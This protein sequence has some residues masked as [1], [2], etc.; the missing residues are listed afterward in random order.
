MSSYPRYLFDFSGNCL[1][2]YIEF[3]L[4]DECFLIGSEPV[5]IEDFDLEFETT[6]GA[7]F[8][9]NGSPDGDLL[10]TQNLT[11]EERE[12]LLINASH[13]VSTFNAQWPP[14][15]FEL[16]I[17]RFAD[18]TDEETDVIFGFNMPTEEEVLAEFAPGG[19]NL[20]VQWDRLA[21]DPN[22]ALPSSIN[23]VELGAVTGVKD[24]GS[25]GSCWAF[26]TAG[27][28]E[29]AAASDPEKAG[30]I[31]GFLQSVSYQQMISCSKTDSGCGGY[32]HEFANN[33]IFGV[34]C[35]FHETNTS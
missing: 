30:F 5:D 2:G 17:N 18:N 14:L 6:V 34:A 8:D 23:W 28:I 19:R 24:Q 26:A 7:D 9:G 1:E 32:V 3:G 22:E 31:S 25:C 20:K 27:L 21:F 4:D 12:A 13:F 35:Y 33:I 11:L 29:G 16:G 10:E 15:H